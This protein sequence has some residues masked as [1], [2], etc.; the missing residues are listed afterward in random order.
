MDRLLIK[1]RLL[2]KGMTL[3]D[4]SRAAGI[5]YDRLVKI[6]CGYRKAR[7]EELAA[8]ASVL[9]V[10]V[11]VLETAEPNP[12]TEALEPSSSSAEARR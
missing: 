5:P 2:D 10:P 4:L 6:L 1:H 9:Q 8:L 3:A 12:G 7:T 11:Q